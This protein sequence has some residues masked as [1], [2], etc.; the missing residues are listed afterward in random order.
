ME[1]HLKERRQLMTARARALARV[2]T[3]IAETCDVLSELRSSLHWVG[4]GTVG[5]AQEN[6]EVALRILT[7]AH[8][9]MQIDLELAGAANLRFGP[10]LSAADL[11]GARRAHDA[12]GLLTVSLRAALADPS[13]GGTIVE[14]GGV[15]RV[16]SFGDATLAEAERA[17]RSLAEEPL[18]DAPG[19]E[20]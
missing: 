12:L 7:V 2:Q 14:R 15:A 13:L 3:S 5:P 6:L 19:P 1:A 8:A 17:F 4:E 11:A 18:A 9:F 16:F 10:L 20:P